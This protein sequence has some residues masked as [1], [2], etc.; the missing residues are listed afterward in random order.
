M[1]CG[2]ARHK[3][4]RERRGDLASELGSCGHYGPDVGRGATGRRWINA[5]MDQCP[6]ENA[7]MNKSQRD[8]GRCVARYLVSWRT[9]E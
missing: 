8:R 3:K 5:P 1:G 2:D 7:P 6:Y 4:A 9:K